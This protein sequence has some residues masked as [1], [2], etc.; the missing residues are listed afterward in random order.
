[1]KARTAMAIAAVLALILGVFLASI[2]ED[3]TAKRSKMLGRIAPQISV[4]TLDGTRTISADEL[5]GKVIIV[6]FW[7]SWCVPCREELPALRSF[8]KE[9]QDDGD[10]VLLGVLR[11]DTIDSA[12]AV[13]ESD[14]MTWPLVDDPGNQLAID[15]GTRGQPETYVIAPDNTIAAVQIGPATAAQLDEMLVVAR[16]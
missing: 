11:D 15:F 6:N 8:W 16:S 9:H 1:M 14:D 7:N 10:V 4:P 2:G 3:P 13:Q 5:A 12:L